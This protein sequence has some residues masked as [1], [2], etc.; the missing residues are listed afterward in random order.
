MVGF[1]PESRI[2]TMERIDGMPFSELC[3]GE[4]ASAVGLGFDTTSSAQKAWS[5]G[6]QRLAISANLCAECRC[7]FSNRWV[8]HLSCISA[9]AWTWKHA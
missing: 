4:E 5:E 8:G 7:C 2:L 3:G 6:P 1:A 9:P